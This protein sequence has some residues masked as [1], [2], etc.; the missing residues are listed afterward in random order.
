MGTPDLASAS[1]W[2]SPASHGLSADAP[3]AAAP[4]SSILVQTSG[5]EGQPK[6]VI[7]S[8]RAFLVSAEAVNRHL[9]A[10]AQN[11]WLIALPTHH[12]GGFSI[13]ARAY[14]SGASV[15]QMAEKWSPQR[16]TDLCAEER[17]T[18]SSLVPTQVFDLVQARLPAPLTLRAIVV[19]G[20]GLAQDIGLAAAELGWPLLQSYG[21]TESASQIATEPLDHLQSGFA[22]DTLEVLPHWQVRTN[23]QN[24]L[25]LQGEAL[26]TG[27]L[28][29]NSAGGW[30][31]ERIGPELVT[32]D[33]V[34]LSTQAPEPSSASWGAIATR[35]RSWAN[36]STC[37]ASNP[38]SISSP[39]TTARTTCSPTSPTTAGA[40]GLILAHTTDGAESVVN[41]FN[42]EARPFERIVRAVRVPEIPRS[43]LGKLR[44][45][46]L[47]A[48]LGSSSF[49]VH[50]SAQC[51]QGKQPPSQP[52]GQQ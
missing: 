10:T 9:A 52:L 18:L 1:F 8:K 34:A 11:R 16:F 43:E 42:T 21:M 35:S 17:I 49:G 13:F 3:L 32:R 12:V 40:G 6:W 41:H 27:Y 26:A 2:K 31:T 37:P 4:P 44:Q 48:M 14:V 28:C 24:Q 39:A 29:Q 51:H 46:E 33:Q 15:H 5:S 7:L 47:R 25:V 20:G 30:Q 50:A 23:A 22:P 38:S 36:S 45:E 19:G